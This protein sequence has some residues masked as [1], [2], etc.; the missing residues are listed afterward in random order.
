MIFCII[1]NISFYCSALFALFSPFY[2]WFSQ[3]IHLYEEVNLWC[4]AA[5]WAQVRRVITAV[6]RMPPFTWWGSV[7]KTILTTRPSLPP[8]YV[9]LSK[10]RMFLHLV[11]FRFSSWSASI[12]FVFFLLWVVYL[13]TV[14]IH[15]FK[16]Y[17]PENPNAVKCQFNVN[18][19]DILYLTWYPE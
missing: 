14:K 16:F 8:H 1:F 7:V 2:I 5:G 15:E 6:W 18:Q 17:L 10:D 11:R 3:V 9:I 12:L 13:Y 4:V 19:F